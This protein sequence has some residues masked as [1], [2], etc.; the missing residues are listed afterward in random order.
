MSISQPMKVWFVACSLAV[1]CLSIYHPQKRAE[2]VLDDY[3]TIVRNPLIKNISLAPK[4][5]T[6]R[7]FDADPSSGYIKFG[8]YRPV[9]QSSFI[10]DYHLFGLNAAGY[11]WINLLIHLFNCLL[12]YF[13]FVEIFGQAP[14]AFKTAVLFSALPSNEWVVRY[15]TGRGDELSALFALGALMFLFKAF[16][17]KD[18]GIYFPVFICWALAALTR[19]VALSYLLYAFLLRDV[20]LEN[21]DI[22]RFSFYWVLIGILPFAVVW[23]IIPRLGN[24]LSLHLLYFASIGLCLWVAQWRAR[25]V[26]L[27]FA[28]F[29]A[30][31]IYQGQFWS[32]ERTLLR[33][34]RTLESQPRTA[35]AQ[36]LLMRYDDD[37]PAINS[38]LESA[39]DPLIQAMWLHRLG[40]VYFA[41]GD[42]A[43]AQRYF[44]QAVMIDP[45]DIDS[46]NALAVVYHDRGQEADSL[47][48]LNRALEI[49]PS[50]PDTLRTLGIH[51]YIGKDFIRARDFLSR[52]L[53]F[54]PDNPQARTLLRLANTSI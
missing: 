51:Y 13:L 4:I 29:A 20:Y 42:L 39:H 43:S 18:K 27:L 3:Y 1:I 26:V 46:L 47:Q 24:I 14:L 30:V 2:F 28:I 10:L 53:Y 50:Y 7:L 38:M 52:C 31:S 35:L 17:S 41:H 49:N 19:E 36:Q 40:T 11:Q 6:S 44:K 12:V 48:C 22:S 15:V 32:T 37:I 23:P 54:D 33:H 34:T 16:K 9:L 21:K 45:L 25:W 8:Y 5:W